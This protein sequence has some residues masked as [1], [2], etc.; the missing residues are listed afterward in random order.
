MIW[1]DLVKCGD[2]WDIGTRGSSF[3]DGL[4]DGTHSRLDD[5]VDGQGQGLSLLGV[6]ST[7][8]RLVQHVPVLWLQEGQRM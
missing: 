3:R 2:R 1:Y 4:D 8:F 6:W 7:S 5:S